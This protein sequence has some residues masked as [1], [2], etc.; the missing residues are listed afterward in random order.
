M[1]EVTLD[2]FKSTLNALLDSNPH[3]RNKGDV[4]KDWCVGNFGI[5]AR[6]SHIREQR[7][8]TNRVSEQF[9]Y[10]NPVVV[11]V[12]DSSVKREGVVKYVLE[13]TYKQLACIAIVGVTENPNKEE[14]NYSYTFERL[15]IFKKSVFS[16]WAESFFDSV[17]MMKSQSFN[18]G[19]S[20]IEIAYPQQIIFYGAP[21]TGKSYKTNEVAKKYSTIRTTFHPD[22]DYS[23]FVGAYKPTTFKDKI[24]G[25]NNFGE[26]KPIIDPETKETKEESKIEYRFVKQAFL[27][28]YVNAWKLFCESDNMESIEPQ[29]LVIEEINRGNCAQIFGD[30]FQLLD[31]SD[32]LSEYPI[33][34]DEDIRKSL[35]NKDSKED[36]SFGE[37]GLQFSDA[38]KEALNDVYNKD[39]D[40]P[41]RDV[42]SEIAIGEVLVLPPNLYIWATMNTSDQS[43]FPIDSAFKRRWDWKYIRICEGKR[44]DGT[45]L[46]YR[47]KFTIPA[48]DE[49]NEEVVDKKW[50]DFIKAINKQIED[51]TKSED[52]KLGFFFCKP[53]KKANDGDD[54]NTIISAETFVG[55]VVFYLWQDVFKD[56]G[57]KSN[58]FKRADNS[59]ISFHDFYPEDM[60]VDKDKNPEGIDLELVKTFINK[61]LDSND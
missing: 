22:S 52:K 28:A 24:Y 19:L 44:E 29:F 45:P 6:I 36:P 12:C 17:E 18:N 8:T 31:R 9:R 46:D 10:F 38:Q 51:A 5:E 16:D 48:K 40:A 60:L 55:K 1:A 41:F 35:L 26:T 27:K 32:G 49:K 56:Y 61:V 58:I 20:N 2:S 54:R 23:T 33:E 57:F 47:I 13:R 3:A 50:W 59:K 30:L 53:D 14:G 25:L 4:F 39:E 21:G 34:A 7:Q 11:F 15:L 37:S 42:A 43:L